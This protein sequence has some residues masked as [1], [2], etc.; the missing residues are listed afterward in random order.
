[1]TALPPSMTLGCGSWGGNVTSDN[2]SPIHLLD[3]KRVAFETR[4]VRSGATVSSIASV[5][6]KPKSVSDAVNISRDEIA[7][8]VDR[9]LGQ[10]QQSQPSTNAPAVERTEDGAEA[11]TM[12]ITAGRVVR[13]AV[14]S[15][16]ANTNN[17]NNAR[18]AT[19]FV[20]EDDVKRAVEK[21]E[22]I[23]ISA[24][25]IITPAAR[26]LGEA[27]EVFTRK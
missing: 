20:C 25:T 24:K 12:H 16:N 5:V 21:G 6:N 23:Y 19:D 7:S 1:S 17:G 22:K 14:S 2:I 18:T 26:D 4:A 8:I 27:A 13:A 15:N 10:R 11:G 3:V 9:F